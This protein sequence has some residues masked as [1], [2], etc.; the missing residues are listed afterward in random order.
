MRALRREAVTAARRPIVAP[1]RVLLPAPPA[2]EPMLEDAAG[3]ILADVV[4]RA[5]ATDA[6]QGE[7]LAGTGQDGGT[8]HH[9]R[10]LLLAAAQAQLPALPH[11]IEESLIDGAH[12]QVKILRLYRERPPAEFEVLVHGGQEL[13]VVLFVRF[14][15]SGLLA[16]TF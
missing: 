14:L 6:E 11:F 4:A 2:I 12:S 1:R 16:L 13:L 5:A 3:A 9:V 7:A 8:G 15:I 10:D